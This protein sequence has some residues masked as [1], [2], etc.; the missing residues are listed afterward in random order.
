MFVMVPLAHYGHSKPRLAPQRARIQHV[1]SS[2]QRCLEITR[3]TYD[4]LLELAD[5][6][7]ISTDEHVV[8]NW[9]FS[10]LHRLVIAL[11]CLSAQQCLRRARQQWGWAVNSVSANV[12][13][14]CELIISRLDVPGSRT[15]SSAPDSARSCLSVRSLPVLLCLC[16]VRMQRVDDG[17]AGRVARC[18]HWPC[19]VPR[20]HWHG[21]C[22]LHQGGAA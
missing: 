14:T 3:L 4:E 7:D 2:D 20:L 8:G 22:N 18:S 21:G 11:Y 6:L 15:C 17:G 16:S 1:L 19:R 12:D 13:A 9:R 5:L 10:P